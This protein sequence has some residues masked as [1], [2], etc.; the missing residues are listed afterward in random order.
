MEILS[1]IGYVLMLLLCVAIIIAVGYGLLF[2]F[3][4]IF[5]GI[6]TLI[7]KSKADKSKQ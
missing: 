1:F 3:G 4:F 2:F 6:L 5:G 7:D